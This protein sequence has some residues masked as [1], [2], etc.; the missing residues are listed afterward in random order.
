M[1]VDGMY[2]PC[3]VAA[4][5]DKIFEVGIGEKHI[6]D[7]FEADIGSKLEKICCYCG[8]FLVPNIHRGTK[9][10]PGGVLDINSITWDEALEKHHKNRSKYENL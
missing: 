8:K 5:I 6:K 7:M 2:Y 9:Y 1:F 4:F 3:P 10:S